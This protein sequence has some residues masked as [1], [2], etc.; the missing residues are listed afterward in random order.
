MKTRTRLTTP[1]GQDPIGTAQQRPEDEHYVPALQLPAEPRVPGRH[2]RAW[3]VLVIV[4]VLLVVGYAVVLVA[5]AG[6]GFDPALDRLPD[7]QPAPIDDSDGG[8][9]DED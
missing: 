5:T 1:P 2:R 7:E 8:L 3:N 9:P 4:A 6:Q